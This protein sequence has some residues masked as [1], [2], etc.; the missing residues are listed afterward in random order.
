[1]DSR[2]RFVSAARLGECPALAQLIG[3]RESVLASVTI[4]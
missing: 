3:T 4:P 1:M 2:Q